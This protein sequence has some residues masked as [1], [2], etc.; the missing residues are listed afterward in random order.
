[1]QGPVLLQLVQS[2]GN[3]SSSNNS[4]S[5]SSSSNGWRINLFTLLG[6]LVR[7]EE[8]LASSL[9]EG[10]GAVGG[11]LA[12]P[13][14]FRGVAIPCGQPQ[15][16]ASPQ[17]GIS[18]PSDMAHMGHMGCTAM[19]DVDRACSMGIPGRGSCPMLYMGQILPSHVVHHVG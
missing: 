6:Q 1:M 16:P 4:S 9:V 18:Q 13:V 17:P 11:T 12:A 7:D 2:S 10:P 5:S 3:S 19:E 15:V 8:G 14:Y